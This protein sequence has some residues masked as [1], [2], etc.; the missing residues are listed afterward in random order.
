MNL[1]QPALNLSFRVISIS[2]QDV[3]I[4]VFGQTYMLPSTAPLDSSSI[5]GFHHALYQISGILATSLLVN[6]NRLVLR[7]IQIPGN[8]AALAFLHYLC[9][10]IF[11]RATS[12]CASS[13]VL[14]KKYHWIWSLLIS[15]LATLSVLASNFILHTSTVTFHQLSKLLALPVAAL[16]D[17][18][19]L[20]KR[21]S[22]LELF[23]LGHVAYGAYIASVGDFTVSRIVMLASVIYLTGYISSAALIRHICKKH[24]LGTSQ[25][26]FLLAPWSAFASLVLLI[27]ALS[28]A[29]GEISVSIDVLGLL[30]LLLNIGLAISVQWLSTWTAA[31]CT[32]MLYAVVGQAKTAVTI[33]I[34]VVIFDSVISFNACVGLCICIAAALM[35]ATI[36]AFQ[37]EPGNALASKLVTGSLVIIACLFLLS[38][39]GPPGGLRVHRKWRAQPEPLVEVRI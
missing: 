9:T 29:V 3:H 35:L 30:S 10:F 23:G 12:R 27:F 15:S 20:Q 7:H 5:A 16:V 11:T 37:H 4:Y 33:I 28:S 38:I 31:N 14:E 17:F 18:F 25:V 32:T 22:L 24:N 34:G 36:E 26:L 13:G 8:Y 21:R 1:S 19:L 39:I 6:S 2:Q